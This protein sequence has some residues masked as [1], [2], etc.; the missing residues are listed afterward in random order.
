MLDARP[1]SQKPARA[2]VRTLSA[3][4]YGQPMPP[5]QVVKVTHSVCPAVQE[6]AM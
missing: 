5:T 4:S 3:E 2:E 6:G 1:N